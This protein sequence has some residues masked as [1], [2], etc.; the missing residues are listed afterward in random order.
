[1]LSQLS[2]APIW[3]LSVPT[4]LIIITKGF[5]FVNTFLKIFLEILFL[6]ILCGFSAENVNIMLIMFQRVD[7]PIDTLADIEKER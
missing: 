1:M 5:R 2:Y 6:Y 4:T 3:L 7:K